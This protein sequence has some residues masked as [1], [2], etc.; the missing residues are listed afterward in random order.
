MFNN[1]GREE[2][3]PSHS[4]PA[5][6]GAQIGTSFLARNEEE[7][8][9]VEQIVSAC[10]RPVLNGENSSHTVHSSVYIIAVAGPSCAGK[11]EL[12]KGLAHELRCSV[13]LLDSYYRDLTAL[14]PA[15]RARV[16]FDAPV[17]LDHEL[18]I[19]QVH[20]LSRGETVERPLYDFATHTCVPRGESFAASEFLIIEGLFA[21][22]WP[23][24]RELAS[25]KVFVD[26]PDDVCLG[27]RQLR[28]VA[29]RGRTLESV[30]TQF[31]QT[32]QPM[33]ALH[34]RPTFKYADLVL[35]GE[36]PLSRSVDTVLKHVRRNSAAGVMLRP[37]GNAMRAAQPDRDERNSLRLELNPR[38]S[39]E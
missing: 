33:A 30:L 5:H 3:F 12:A 25:T 15:E 22:Y 20:A 31:N 6:N 17:A 7:K 2:F 26:A 38:T 11:T 8:N 1:S 34:V 21:L 35:S 27:R 14:A 32:V 28:D 13:L 24:L 9:A 16:N 18:L 29:E 19:E 36:Q 39:V 37:C 23:E 4:F 10:V